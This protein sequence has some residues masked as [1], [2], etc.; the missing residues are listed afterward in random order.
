[1]GELRKR[2]LIGERVYIVQRGLKKIWTAE[3]H[4]AGQHARKSLR[5]RNE[6]VARGKAARLEAELS[7]GTYRPNEGTARK[8]VKERCLE[9]IS[10]ERARDEF[11]AF[12]ETNGRSKRTRNKLRSTLTCLQSFASLRQATLVEEIDLR[13]FDAFRA[14]RMLVRA[15][16]TVFNESIIIKSFLAW[17]EERKLIASNPL[18][19]QFFPKPRSKP[20]GGPALEQVDQIID[21]LTGQYR[22][23]VEILAF[24]GMRS[25]ECRHL[26]YDLGDVDLANNWI[27]IESRDGAETKTRESRKVPI[28]PRLRAVLEGLPKQRRKWFLTQKP[29]KKYP[30]GDHWLNVKHLNEAFKTALGK[31]GIP[32]GNKESGFYIHSLRSFF[33]THCV[34]NNIPREIIDAW[35]GH[36]LGRRASDQYYQLTDA[37]SQ[38]KMKSVPFGDGHVAGNACSSRSTNT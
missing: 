27:H 26:R 33:K 38:E 4:I 16:K 19:N 10:I 24:T 37:V 30:N 11:I 12:K 18:K 32:A 22:I 20:K 31:L 5:T 28:H 13:L 15:E 29:S 35:Q 25:G 7:E 1:M 9:Y 23:A 17:C 3:F 6:K 21:Q 8:A 14:A 36:A 34:N 2:I